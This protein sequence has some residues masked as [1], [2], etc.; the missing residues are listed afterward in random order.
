MIRLTALIC[1]CCAAYPALVPSDSPHPSMPA[2]EAEG[3]GGGGASA[4]PGIPLPQLYAQ[5]PLLSDSVSRSEDYGRTSGLEPF[6]LAPG[7]SADLSAALSNAS[8]RR[9]Q[10]VGV[11]W[12]SAQSTIVATTPGNWVSL[13]TGNP[14][15]NSVNCR[16]IVTLPGPSYFPVVQFHRFNTES[17]YDYFTL[18]AQATLSG[19][20]IFASRSGTA[21]NPNPQVGLQSITSRLSPFG[22]AFVFTSDGSTTNS[23]V[24]I[25]VFHGNNF[26]TATGGTV[27][28]NAGGLLYLTALEGFATTVYADNL[29]CRFSVGAPAGYVPSFFIR[30]LRT[31]TSLDF[32]HFYD[33]GATSTLPASPAFATFGGV[34]GI[35][36]ATTALCPSTAPCSSQCQYAGVRFTSDSTTGQLGGPVVVAQTAIVA[37]GFYRTLTGCTTL[38]NAGTYG[39]TPAMTV[40][41]CTGPCSAGYYG[42]AATVR[43]ASTCDGLVTCGFFSTAGATAATGSG[44]CAAGRYGLG[45]S[46][47][48]ASTC[49]GLCSAGYYCPAGSCSATQVICPIGNYCPSGNGLQTACPAGTFGAITGLSTSACTGQCAAGYFGSA[50]AQTASTCSG[51]VTCGYFSTAGAT[52]ATGSGQCAAGRYGLGTSVRIASTCDGLC[53]A[54]YYC[55]TGSCSATQVPCAAGTYS[56]ASGAATS[57]TCLP[58]AAGTYSTA[59]G[60]STSATCLPCAAG[61][62]SAAIGATSAATCAPVCPLGYFC[63]PGTFLPLLCPPGFFGAAQGLTTSSCSGACSAPP[64]FGCAAGSTSSANATVCAPGFFC[65]GGS[66]APAVPCMVPGNCGASGLAAEPPCVWSVNTLAGTGSASFV[67]GV[68]LAAFNNPLGLAGDGSGVVYVTDHGNRRIRKVTPSGAVSLLAGSGAAAWADGMGAAASFREPWGATVHPVTGDIFCADRG[69]HRIRRITPAGVASTF[70]GSGLAAWADGAGA[71]ASFRGPEGLVIDSAGVVFV[72]DTQN[73]RI[74]RITPLGAVTTL[75]GTGAAAFADGM[76]TSAAFNKPNSLALD[77]R[78]DFFIGDFG[79]RRVRKMAPSGAVT[80]FAGSGI[81]AWADGLG[82]AASFFGPASLVFAANGNLLLGDEYNSRLRMVTPLGAVTTLAGGAGG[83]QDGFGT[84][85][86]FSGAYGVAID[87]SGRITAA[88]PG[89][90]RLRTLTCMQCP[91]GYS[92]DT[93]IPLLCPPGAYCPVNASAFLPPVQCPAGTFSGAGAAN[94]TQCPAGSLSPSTGSTSCQQCPGGHFCP[95]GTSSWA[96]LNCGRGNYC[97][98]GSAAPLPCPL[99]VPPSGGWGALKVQGPAFFVETAYCLNQ[100]FWNFTSGDGMLSAC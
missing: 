54:G 41:T 63:P 16:Q 60:A 10:Q 83:Y 53:S 66:P 76:G 59:S 18:Y 52:A 96:N 24:G 100:C 69:D 72:A 32:L 71:S 75:A 51:L 81:G 49:D 56:T 19:T 61:T 57:A 90:H 29:N 26:C 45:T 37:A 77:G 62:F 92:C 34:S 50:T 44:Q 88:D 85:A 84:A 13:D 30:N 3:G 98:F 91:P 64:G 4:Q 89:N 31:E 33:Q 48:T 1:F 12:C 39:A 42:L 6:V 43:T 58:C 97:P 36:G 82:T 74:R 35:S 46:V 87:A 73:H 5:A 99:Q 20:T 22:L 9:A 79:G 70:A 17:G 95:P 68:A 8:S 40:A 93:G 28:L 55:P 14:Y 11:A 67:D 78:G 23:G 21:V 27:S 47:R 86:L 15:V 94:C 25:T 80:T 38:C 7:E 65:P 2:L